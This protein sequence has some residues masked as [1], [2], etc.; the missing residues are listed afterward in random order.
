MYQS[1][2]PPP[3]TYPHHLD[4]S[5][6][7]PPERFIKPED[8]QTSSRHHHMS[9][10]PTSTVALSHVTSPM[11]SRPP[12]KSPVSAAI[13]MTAGTRNSPL[14]LASIT[15]PFHS[16]PPQHHQ[17]KNCHAQML[18]P[19]ERLRTGF[20][21][22]EGP[23]THYEMIRLRPLLRSRLRRSLS[24]GPRRRYMAIVPC[25][26]R[27]THSCLYACSRNRPHHPGDLLMHPCPRSCHHGT[28]TEDRPFPVATDG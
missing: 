27:P 14:S 17:S 15:S 28:R 21:N 20:H 12:E 19:G 6:Q 25:N 23:A 22:L 7:G 5:T 1:M 10:G 16:E 2:M 13:G 26:V 8:I 18:M 3:H 9:I 24:Q 11:R 4:A